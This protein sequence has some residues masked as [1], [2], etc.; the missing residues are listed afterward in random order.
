MGG[1]SNIRGVKLSDF[2]DEDFLNDLVLDQGTDQ[3]NINK[4]DKKPL[5][6]LLSSTL[7]MSTIL[8][9][10]LTTETTMPGSNKRRRT[11]SGDIQVTHLVMSPLLA[12]ILSQSDYLMN[13]DWRRR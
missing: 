10:T 13:Q 9:P 7:T 6:E 5:E 2:I 4:S 12:M 3:A 11:E 1:H 8:L